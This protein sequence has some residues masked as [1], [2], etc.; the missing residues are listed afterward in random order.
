M[1][2]RSIYN[3]YFHP[4]AAVPGPRLYAISSAPYL[5]R[6]ASGKWPFI[7]KGL[8]DKYGP[9][10]RFGPN[11]ASLITPNS[12]K[13]IY[14]HHN[15]GQPNFDKDLR[16]YRQ[17]KT[18][19]PNILVANDTDHSRFRRLLSHG[20]SEKALRGQEGVM[21]RYI[22][23]LITR[24][25]EC[26]RVKSGIMDMVK[27]YNFT[28]FDLIGDLAFGESF[29]CLDSGGY[30]PWVAMIFDGFRLSAYILTVKYYPWL[31]RPVMWFIPRSLKEKQQQNLSLSFEKVG[32]RVASGNSER[33][34]FISYILRHQDDE[35]FAMNPHEL[36]ENSSILIV[37]GSETTATLLSGTTYLILQDSR[38]YQRLI[39]EIRSTFQKEGDINLSSVGNLSY[40]IAVFSEALRMYP[41][42]PTGLPRKV[43][44]GGKSLSGY[45]FP[46]N[47]RHRSS[48]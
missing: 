7:L 10:V 9:V 39:R 46:E 30:H 20:F 43:P 5:Y 22:D 33:E 16:I 44:A 15:S 19:A 21:K 35:K 34:D 45:Y 18:G 6:V 11:D 2:G 23:K 37:A 1:L 26:A 48:Q 38:I 3:V 28:T 14:G 41:P 47:V 17:R 36:G 25:H 4:L 40:L 31:E 27:W 42:V 32:K 12:W 24:M 13:D 29:G 8:H